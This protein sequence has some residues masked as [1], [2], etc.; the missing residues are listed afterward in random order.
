MMKALVN[1]TGSRAPRA[2]RSCLVHGCA[3]LLLLAGVRELFATPPKP[4]TPVEVTTNEFRCLGRTTE[5]GKFLLPAQITA[6]EES[7][8]ASPIQIVSEP[9]IFSAIKGRAKVVEKSEDSARLEWGGESEDFS[10]ASKMTADCDGFCWYEIRLTPKHPT[11]LR[12]LALEIPRSKKTARYFHSADFSWSNVSQ[13]LPELGGKWS[14]AFKPYLWLGDEARGLGWCA[15]SNEGW[16]LKDPA[17]AL[18]IETRGEVVSLKV[19]WLDHEETL[20]SSVT[21]RFGLQSSPVKPVS[22]AWRTNARILHN[23]HYDFAKSGPDGRCELDRLAEG[24]VK[25]VVI[26]DD[27]TKYFGQ[28][29]PADTKQFRQLIDACHKRKMRLLVYVGYG[30]ARTAPELQGKHDEWSVLPLIPWEPSYKPETRSFDATCPNSGWADWLVAGTE[31][32]FSDYALDG[33]YFDG[34]AYGWPCQNSAHGCGWKSVQGDVHTVYPV[35][36]ARKL[37]R[38]IADTVHRHKPDAILD[39]HMSSNFTLPT[40]AFCDSVWNGEQFESHTAAE[41][42]EV[43]LHFFRTEFMGY[44]QGL[45][46]EFLCYEDRPFTFDEAITLAWLHGVEVRPYPP[47]LAKVVPLWRAMDNFGITNAIW[48]PYWSGSSVASA[49]LESVKISAWTRKGKALL[50]VSHLE[51]KPA[52]VRLAV[53]STKIGLKTFT[54]KDA[55]NETPIA[56]TEGKIELSFT[57]MSYRLLELRGPS[58]IK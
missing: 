37:M 42:F 14:G 55:I 27:W 57:N 53:E 38:R 17:K 30:L 40:L 24:G 54:V 44:A 7:L 45:D 12:S 23:I 50:F 39:A 11:K 58:Q 3:A 31:K 51:R 2:P 32:L 5:L 49:D 1:S 19:N 26:H 28:M 33:L 16:R 22:F 52:T 9:D 48:R 13:G 56:L 8:L 25:T 46:A 36:A 34:T 43:P 15:E 4:F 6:A 18:V 10:I 35:L 29:A 47:T 21:F 41:K 20:D